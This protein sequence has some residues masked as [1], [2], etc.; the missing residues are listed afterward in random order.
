M[1]LRLTA[2]A[3]A[4]AASLGMGAAG[5]TSYADAAYAGASFSE[6]ANGIAVSDTGVIAA[7]MFNPR[8]VTFVDAEG[9]T[10]SVEI[11]CSPHDVAIS[12]S[13]TT[14]W[15]VCQGSSHLM[16]IDVATASVASASMNAPGLDDV[17]Y[18]PRVDQ[19]ILSSMDGLGGQI[20]RVGGVTTGAYEVI[21]RI[22]TPQWRV[23]QLAPS[24]DGS[25]A[26]ALTD[27][28]DLLRVDFQEGDSLTLIRRG[29]PDRSYLSIAVNPNYTALYAAVLDFSDPADMRTSLE[30]IQPATGHPLQSVPLDYAMSISTSIDIAAGHRT[31]AV[32]SGVPIRQGDAASGLVVVPLDERG[33]L[34]TPRP[35]ES[36]AIGTA[37]GMSADGS[38]IAFAT[39]DNNVVGSRTYGAPYPKAIEVTATARG[40][41]LTVSGTT[42]SLDYRTPLTVW[43]KDL[44]RSKA[45]FVKKSPGALVSSTGA[46]AWKG[47]P[48][49]KRFALYLSGGGTKSATVTVTV[50]R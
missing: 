26:Y 28:G 17:T 15:A 10:S 37:V 46:V 41:V 22:A 44:T 1:G 39:S 34:G 19:L 27:S 47:T 11:G 20:L 33:R 29:S 25:H 35:E 8:T 45:R 18:L 16:V 24:A 31:L 42:T 32:A 48:P 36:D 21:D 6:P 49:S 5:A 40:T 2:V 9:T 14:A 13:G 7:A 12:P 23:T 4:C 3:I 43:V 50:R 38:W 30:L